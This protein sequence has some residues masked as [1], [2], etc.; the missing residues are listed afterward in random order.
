MGKGSVSVS[1]RGWQR[2]GGHV[3]SLRRSGIEESKYP[4]D[5]QV[6]LQQ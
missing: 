5:G 2:A 4:V 1:G 3:L 6:F